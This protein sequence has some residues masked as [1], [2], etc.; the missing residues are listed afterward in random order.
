MYCQTCIF[1]NSEKW[2]WIMEILSTITQST[3]KAEASLETVANVSEIRDEKD[4]N[5]LFLSFQQMLLQKDHKSSSV[6][7]DSNRSRYT[8]FNGTENAFSCIKCNLLF[9]SFTYKI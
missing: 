3:M 6:L 2:K 9:R 5:D 7:S 1:F 4:Q 8:S